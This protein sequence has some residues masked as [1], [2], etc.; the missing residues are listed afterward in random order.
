MHFEPNK[1]IESNKCSKTLP[2]NSNT[3]VSQSIYVNG[4]KFK[5]VS[6][7]KFLGVVL[8]DKLDWAPRIH[9]LN[10]KLRST[11]AQISSIRHWIPEEQYLKIYYALFE[12]HLTYGISVWGGVCDSKLDKKFL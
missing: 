8:D 12:S 4:Q 7:T 6:N 11:A 3:H 10:K 5:E 1:F 2:F 9:E